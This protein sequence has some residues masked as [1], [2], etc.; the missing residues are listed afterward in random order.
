MKEFRG[1]VFSMTKYGI[2][3]LGKNPPGETVMF[4]APFEEWEK[5]D[6]SES[7]VLPILCSEY[8]GYTEEESRLA[9][10]WD[11]RKH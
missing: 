2:L 7:F 3:R 5:I 6:I 1:K 8:K 10:A 4:S 11:E 9:W